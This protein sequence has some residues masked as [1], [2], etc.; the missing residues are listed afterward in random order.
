MRTRERDEQVV[1]SNEAT[2]YL[3]SA[4]QGEL[5]DELSKERA[6]RTSK[7]REDA[8]RSQSIVENNAR[9][10]KE[11]EKRSK[12]RLA[13]ISNAKKALQLMSSDPQAMRQ[14]VL[15]MNANWKEVSK[16]A[17]KI[18]GGDQALADK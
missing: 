10:A 11:G 9:L 3:L 2:S 6:D 18:L 8:K 7:A 16:E 15:Y 1:E 5:H 17:A 13:A 12:D 4:I 14:R